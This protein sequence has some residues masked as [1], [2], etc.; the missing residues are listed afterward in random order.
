MRA[1]FDGVHVIRKS[2]Y[3]FVICFRILHCHLSHRGAALA[4]NVY[5]VLVY[6]VDRLFGIYI[7]HK[8]LY[9]AFKAEGLGF[10]LRIAFVIEHYT[11]TAVEKR[12]L[13]QT[14]TYYLSVKH[15]LF[16]YGIVGPE[17]DVKPVLVCISYVLYRVFYLTV[18]E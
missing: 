11:Y 14:C 18:F 17:P 10:M 3:L 12:L 15:G 7:L 13:A 2:Q 1:A 8:A 16:E 6:R 4:G 5:N 9:P